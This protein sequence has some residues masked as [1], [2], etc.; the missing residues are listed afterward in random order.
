MSKKTKSKFYVSHALPACAMALGS[1]AQADTLGVQQFGTFATVSTGT[2]FDTV[3]ISTVT[4]SG[5]A[6]VLLNGSFAAVCIE[7]LQTISTE[8]RIGGDSSY[9]ASFTAA[10]SASVQK[11]F[12][13]YYGN[14]STTDSAAAPFALALQELLLETSGSYSLASGAYQR[15]G[16]SAA[17]TQAVASANALLAG[18]AAAPDATTHLQLVSFE[19]A[20][21]Q[22]FIGAVTPVPEPET[23]ALLLA[24]LG[25]IGLA[26]RRRR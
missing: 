3:G 26:M 9:T 15:I 17:D 1:A 6:N 21:S 2:G 24:G 11:L 25:V 14:A 18:L 13:L 19:S 8:A 7:P 20:S 16:L 22:D 23:Y 4:N 10:P 12:D 5:N